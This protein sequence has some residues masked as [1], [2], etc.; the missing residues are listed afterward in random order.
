MIS[1]LG[2]RASLR[3][4]TGLTWCQGTWMTS[5]SPISLLPEDKLRSRI[6]WAWRFWAEVIEKVEGQCLSRS[7]ERRVSQLFRGSLESP[8]KLPVFL[9]VP[10]SYRQHCISGGPGRRFRM[11]ENKTEWMVV[12]RKRKRMC[13]QGGSQAFLLKCPGVSLYEE[14]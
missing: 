3:P 10:E 6:R 5:P 13:D 8:H 1:T 11:L 14:G 7:R 4:V 9:F 12:E 2:H